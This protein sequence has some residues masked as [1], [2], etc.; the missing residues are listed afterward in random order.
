MKR[1]G[2]HLYLWHLIRL[3]KRWSVVGLMT[4]STYVTRKVVSC[5]ASLKATRHP[6][7][8]S[9]SRQLASRSD[10]H[11]IRLWSCETWET[12]A[13]IK[14]PT[15]ENWFIRAL[16]FHPKLTQLAA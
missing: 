7:S 16:A 11:T 6:S 9:H 4:L 3:A 1:T 14:N 5:C 15:L 12:V 13:V 2:P 8:L 10:D